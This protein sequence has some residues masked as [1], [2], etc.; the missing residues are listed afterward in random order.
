M[1]FATLASTVNAVDATTPK[2]KGHAPVISDVEVENITRPGKQPRIRDALR[3]KYTFR[4][5]D[6]DLNN[7]TT[8]QWRRGG[9]NIA[10]G[11]YT[12]GVADLYES[13]TVVVTPKTNQATTDPSSGTPVTSAA[14]TV[15]PTSVGRFLSPDRLTRS[16][17]AANSYCQGLGN[18]ARLPTNAELIQLFH[19]S[20]SSTYNN[21]MCTEYGWP[22]SNR[23]RGTTNSYWS[24]TPYKPIKGHHHTVIMN[25]ARAEASAGDENTLHVACVR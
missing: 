2:V 17:A 4:D 20:T 8:L 19:D 9:S 21:Q 7:G 24:S 13:L 23:C 16:W 6:G 14:I 15:L 12:V 22:L 25:E 11:V 3:A 10:I 5:I 18:G 1:L